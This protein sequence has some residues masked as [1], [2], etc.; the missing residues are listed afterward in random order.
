MVLSV[1]DVRVFHFSRHDWHCRRA[2]LRLTEAVED[3]SP[4]EMMRAAF[5]MV[6]VDKS[7]YLDM[8]EV[9]EALKSLDSDLNEA[10]TTESLPLYSKC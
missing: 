5:D 7:G 6:D 8:K 9:S 1:H 4:K 10:G 2:M 3:A